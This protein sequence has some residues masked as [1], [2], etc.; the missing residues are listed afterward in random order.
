MYNYRATVNEIM[1]NVICIGQLLLKIFTP[2]YIIS[3]WK[4]MPAY[5][6]HMNG[7]ELYIGS[8]LMWPR[9][10]KQ[11]G[12]WVTFWYIKPLI[13]RKIINFMSVKLSFHVKLMFRGGLNYLDSYILTL[14]FAFKS[15]P[16]P[17]VMLNAF[18]G[19]VPK[20][21]SKDCY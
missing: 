12:W 21:L 9:R 10:R 3:A 14:C 7:K 2:H 13:T 16:N 6:V 11:A 20:F 5:A 18:Y 4:L 15:Q 8:I 19:F 1:H 17:K